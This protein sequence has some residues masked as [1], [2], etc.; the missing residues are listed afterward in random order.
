MM[1]LLKGWSEPDTA[2]MHMFN[3]WGQHTA[4]IF[5]LFSTLFKGNLS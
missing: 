3:P 5:T 4:M 2:G 1:Y